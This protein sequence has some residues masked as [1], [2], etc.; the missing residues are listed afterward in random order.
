MRDI[1]Q[2][3]KIFHIDPKKSRSQDFY[4]NMLELQQYVMKKYSGADK[5]PRDFVCHLCGEKQGEEFLALKNYQLFECKNCGLVSPNIN[6]EM[7]HEIYESPHYEKDTKREILDT[8]EY[9]KATYG[10]ERYEYIAEKIKDLHPSE[11]RVAD[12]GCG[13]GYFI[14]YLKEKNVR[15]K[16]IEMTDYLVNICKERNLNVSKSRIEDEPDES[17]N[18]ITLFDVLEHIDHPIRFFSVLAKKL[19]RPGYVLAYTPHI[20]SVAYA[21]MKEKQNTLYPYQHIAFYDKKSL[22][23]LAAQTGFEVFSIDYYGLDVMDYFCYLEY[24][25]GYDYLQ[26]IKEFIPLMQATIDRQKLS[27]HMRIIFKKI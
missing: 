19:T 2:G 9:R 13:P 23:Y 8:Y 5:Q 16:G 22:E 25:D 14:E 20:H 1:F 3:Y 6:L 17:S 27:N 15:Y 10:R 26:N 24:R 11:M 12:V 4:K 18:V 21:L 7:L